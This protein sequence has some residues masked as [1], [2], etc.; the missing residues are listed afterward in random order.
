MPSV[1]PPRLGAAWLGLVY[2]AAVLASTPGCSPIRVEPAQ[3]GGPFGN[4]RLSALHRGKLSPRTVQTLRQRDLDHIYEQDPNEA[5]ARLHDLAC[6]GHQPDLLFALAE[7]HFVRG[8]ESEKDRGCEPVAH[9]YLCAG[10]AYHYLFDAPD[11][12]DAARASVF[13]PRFRLACD[14]Y[15]AGLAQCIAAAQRVGQLDPK[16]E[17]RIPTRDGAFRL[18]VTHDGFAWKPEEFGPLLLCKDYKVEGLANHYRGYAVP[19]RSGEPSLPAARQLPGDGLLPLRGDR[20]RPGRLPQ[21][22]AGDVQP[23]VRPDRGS[24]RPQRSSGN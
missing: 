18:S 5:I 2:A 10:Y 19:Q 11:G 12:P 17:L 1:R 23:A 3:A 13:D 16:K 7:I 20:G 22:P 4:W 24:V 15:N 9:Y 6:Q 14:L 21:R 8:E